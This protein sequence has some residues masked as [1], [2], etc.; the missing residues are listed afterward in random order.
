MILIADS[1]SSK[2]QWRWFGEQ[3]GSLDTQGI[4]PYYISENELVALLQNAFGALELSFSEIYFFG[5]GCNAEDKN[6]LV[7][8][9]LHRLWPSAI[10][11]VHSDL[12]A[13][14]LASAGS[15]PGIC[16]ILGTGANSCLFDG[17]EIVDNI[18]PLGF[19]L[20]D[21]GSGAYLGKVLINYLYKGC[22][23]EAL[24]TDFEETYHLK[25]TDII[26]RT[27]NDSYPNRF[28]ASFAPF[29]LKHK[30]EE[31]VKRLIVNAFDAF[32]HKNVL[33]YY[34]VQ[35]LPIHFTGS[36]A[37]H[38]S[39]ELTEVIEKNGLQMGRIVQYPMDGLLEF[40][41]KIKA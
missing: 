38:F 5:A 12:M 13:S 33:L 18:P 16:C 19:I 37:T 23:N 25:V 3:T 41:K 6:T 15:K 24:K 2:T 35:Q 26:K 32:L 10:V 9:A 31:D 8:N 21:E 17:V 34:G 28:L 27:Y 29:L 22:R 1:G 39:W 40:Y 4:N 30:A 11:E 7:I 14:C 20:G 36:I